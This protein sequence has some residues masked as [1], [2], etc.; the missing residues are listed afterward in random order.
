MSVTQNIES[1]FVPGKSAELSYTIRGAVSESAASVELSAACPSTFEGLIRKERRIEAVFV[2]ST[3]PAKNIWKGTVT[4]GSVDPDDY[5]TSF[6]TTGGSQHVTQTLQTI[7]STPGA[8]NMQGAIG[9]DGQN[10]NGVDIIVPV[11]NFSETHF[12]TKLFVNSSYR[13]LLAAMTGSVNDASFRGHAG[14]EVQ[15]KGASGQLVT[16]E[17]GQ[18]WQLTYNFAVSPNRTNITVGSFT[19]ASKL[20]W[21][22]LW[23]LYGDKVDTG[24][25]V[26]QPIAAYVERLYPF[27]DFSDLGI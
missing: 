14:G 3:H 20:G 25:L 6:D 5:T 9:Y 10:V 15:F 18:K 1:N 21:D 27:A 11:Y 2:D 22:Y 19:I 24:R 7:F 23:V 8:P 26:Q 12:K 13:N 17:T 16:T 4:Y